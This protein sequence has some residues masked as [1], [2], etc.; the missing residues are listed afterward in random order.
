MTAH[1]I[2]VPVQVFVLAACCLAIA[3]YRWRQGKKYYLTIAWWIAI[4]WAVWTVSYAGYSF[5]NR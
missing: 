1:Q 5:L 2:P 4:A 3:W